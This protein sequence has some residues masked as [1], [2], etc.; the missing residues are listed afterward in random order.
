MDQ[1]LCADLVPGSVKYLRQDVISGVRPGDDKPAVTKARHGG[2][3]L[4]TTRGRVDQ[5]LGGGRINGWHAGSL[6]QSAVLRSEKALQQAVLCADEAQFKLLFAVS[7]ANTIP[8]SCE[9][10]AVQISLRVRVAP[11]SV[12]RR[13]LADAPV[14]SGSNSRTLVVSFQKKVGLVDVAA[15]PDVTKSALANVRAAA[16]PPILPKPNQ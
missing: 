3:V 10:Y 9:G 11:V 13:T 6:P 8:L 1:N 2:K 16:G 12:A 4:V 5:G 14:P 15:P 7:P